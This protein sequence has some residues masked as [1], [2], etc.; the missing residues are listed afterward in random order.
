[1]ASRLATALTNIGWHERFFVAF[2]TVHC[3]AASS[4][5]GVAQGS[6]PIY[7]GLED[8]GKDHHSPIRFRQLSLD[9]NT[10]FPNRHTLD[11][12]LPSR[13]LNQ[14]SAIRASCVARLVRFLSAIP[15]QL[16]DLVALL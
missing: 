15:L 2:V 1:M 13:F 14:S 3:V 12:C 4:R 9:A 16:T 10:M 6:E 11:R 8:G 5:D 7:K